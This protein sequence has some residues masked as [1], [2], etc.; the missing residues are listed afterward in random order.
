MEIKVLVV[1]NLPSIRNIVRNLLKDMG[2]ND[3]DEAGDGLQ[4]MEKLKSGD[5]GLV[6]ASRDI[7]NMSGMELL[8]KIREND[9][10]QSLPFIMITAEA[11][12][13]KVLE[14]IQAGINGYIVKPFTLEMLRKNIDRVLKSEGIKHAKNNIDS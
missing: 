12:S 3:A 8:K 11:E 7:P 1:D 9:K 2:F 5:Y 6:I 4:A 14:A 13:K 10:L